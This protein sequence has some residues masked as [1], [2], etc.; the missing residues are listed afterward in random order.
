MVRWQTW[1]RLTGRRVTVTGKRAGFDLGV[2]R[3]E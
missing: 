2:A 1:Q 3:F